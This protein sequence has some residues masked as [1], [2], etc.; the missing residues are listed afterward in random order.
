MRN[1]IRHARSSDEGFT[2]IELLIVIVVLGV[3]SGITVFGVSA[4]KK[5]SEDAACAASK[6]TV[7][8]AADAYNAKKGTYP[9]STDVLFTEGYLKTKPVGVTL[10]SA[11]T[12]PTGTCTAATP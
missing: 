12:E 6:K 10:G 1:R 8:V 11:T 4:F 9:T 5:D 7:S 3:L 2:L